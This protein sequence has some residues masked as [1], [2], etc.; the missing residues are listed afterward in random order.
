MDPSLTTKDMMMPASGR[1]DVHGPPLHS[2]LSV[3][4]LSAMGDEV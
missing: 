3:N 2:E 4:D 1:L